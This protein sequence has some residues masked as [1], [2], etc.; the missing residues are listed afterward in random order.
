M[1]GNNLD[2]G[3]GETPVRQ[4]AQDFET[5]EQMAEFL[6]TVVNGPFSRGRARKVGEALHQAHPALQAQVVAF[7]LG[8][9]EGLAT[10]PLRDLDERNED[11]IAQA[12]A[13]AGLVKDW[14]P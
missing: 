11:T 1:Y 8:V 3:P 2:D 5:P 13:V 12:R 4:I 14:M 10:L 7:C 9:V 6:A